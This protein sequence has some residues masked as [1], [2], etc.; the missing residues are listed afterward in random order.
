MSL[1]WFIAGIVAALYA[2]KVWPRTRIRFCAILGAALGLAVALVGKFMLGY[3]FHGTLPVKFGIVFACFCMAAESNER[4]KVKPRRPQAAPKEAAWNGGYLALEKGQKHFLNK[5]YQEALD[6]LDIALDAGYST[7]DIHGMRATCLQAL[8]WHLDAIDEYT[9]TI[10]LEPNDCNHY[11]QRAMSKSSIGDSKGCI[12]DIER[13]MA[14]ST[15]NSRLNRGYNE[16]AREI[17]YE[18][19]ADLYRSQLSFESDASEA[20][21]ELAAR[22]ANEAQQKGRRPKKVANAG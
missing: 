16:V 20:H 2:G 10:A 3:S 5:Q 19:A 15:A 11:Y 8:G 17:G 18:S 7:A 6:S 13:A 12:A 1:P 21:M 4:R 22:L 14:L 9:R